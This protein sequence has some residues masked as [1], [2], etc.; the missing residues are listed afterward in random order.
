[1]QLRDVTLS[2]TFALTPGALVA[3]IGAGGKTTLARTIADELAGSRRTVAVTTTTKIWPPVDMPLVMAGEPE[4]AARLLRTSLAQTSLAAVGAELNE[5]GKV[6]GLDPGVVCAVLREGV[7]DFVLCEA[8][9]AAGR[10]L[11]A[12]AEH[13]PVIPDCTSVVV[14]VAGVDAIGQDI[15]RVVHRPEL[16]ARQLQTDSSP[17]VGPEHVATALVNAGRFAPPNASVL[18]A[19]NKVDTQQDLV[20]AREVARLVLDRVPY[21]RV[22]STSWGRVVDILNPERA[23][24]AHSCST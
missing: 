17:L 21:S 11:K 5:S 19:I 13:E 7:A 4:R 16:F 9:G 22:V 2:A 3:F 15:E 20:A 18:F 1:M 10:S 12:H 14:V 24:P 23:T 8:D 6:V